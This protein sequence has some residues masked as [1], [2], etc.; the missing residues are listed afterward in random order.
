V[1]IYDDQ[2]ISIDS[3]KIAPFTNYPNFR[4]DSEINIMALISKIIKTI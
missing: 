4:I 3:I 1:E 2:P